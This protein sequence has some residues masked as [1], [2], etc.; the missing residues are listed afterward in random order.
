M[1]NQIGPTARLPPNQDGR[2]KK[3]EI[4]LPNTT[5]TSSVYH[6]ALRTHKCPCHIPTTALKNTSTYSALP[7]STTI[8]YKVKLIRRQRACLESP[9]HSQKYWRPTKHGRCKFHIKTSTY[10]GLIISPSCIDMYPDKVKAVQ[11]W[12]T[13]K[14]VK[15]IQAFLGLANFYCHFILGYSKVANSLTILT[16]KNLI[17][18]WTTTAQQVFDSLKKAFTTAPIQAHVDRD[19]EIVVE[20]D[21]SDYVCAAVHSQHDDQNRLRP[22]AYFSKKTLSRR[23]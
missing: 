17:F 15:E 7:T 3:I 12:N 9:H 8:R 22:V 19:K 11:D 6:H 1:V 5:W 20:T 14:R 23:M 21:E 4:L 13:P 2:R 10:L 16:S 18:Q